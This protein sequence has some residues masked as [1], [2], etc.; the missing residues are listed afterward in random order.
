MHADRVSADT[1]DQ[2]DL[3]LAWGL[4][5]AGRVATFDELVTQAL[6]APF[7][8]WDFSWLAAR[9]TA[10]RLPWS[11]QGEVARR[12]AQADLSGT[13]HPGRAMSDCGVERVQG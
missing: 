6:N 8:G 4:C 5:E 11:Y 12:A 3:I 1:P 2:Q 9:S 10:G 13:G 7:S